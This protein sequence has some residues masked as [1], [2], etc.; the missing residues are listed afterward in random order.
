MLQ[1][2]KTPLHTL[3]YRPVAEPLGPSE[4]TTQA[5]ALRRRVCD[6]LLERREDFEPFIDS[7]FDIYV[8]NQR[9][10]SAWGGEPLEEVG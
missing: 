3:L 6:E 2:A 8:R 4:E 10:P 1:Y 5:D 7:D 9:R